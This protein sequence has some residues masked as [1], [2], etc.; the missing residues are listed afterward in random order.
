MHV[1]SNNLNARPVSPYDAGDRTWDTTVME[2]NL[3]NKGFHGQFTVIGLMFYNSCLP[4][5]NRKLLVA[6]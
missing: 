5:N 6:I 2:K 1:P 4:C 3:H